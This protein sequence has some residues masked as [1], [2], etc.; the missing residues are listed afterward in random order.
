MVI[1]KVITLKK[2]KLGRNTKE[3]LPNR[4]THDH[5]VSTGFPMFSSSIAGWTKFIL[6]I[7]PV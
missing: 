6:V 4:M 7:R 2:K 1:S 3:G 5:P